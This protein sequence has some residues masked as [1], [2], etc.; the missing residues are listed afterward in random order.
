M[1]LRLRPSY[2]HA[3]FSGGKQA[4][5]VEGTC[6]RGFLM[7]GVRRRLAISVAS[8]CAERL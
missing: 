6:S 5:R 1:G 4:V 7:L 8:L 2:P 3:L